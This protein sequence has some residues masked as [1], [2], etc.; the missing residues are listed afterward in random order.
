MDPFLTIGLKL[1]TEPDEYL[2]RTKLSATVAELDGERVTEIQTEQ[3][4]EKIEALQVVDDIEEAKTGVVRLVMASKSVTG[5]KGQAGQ[6]RRLLEYC[7]KGAGDKSEALLAAMPN[8]LAQSIVAEIAKV[9]D[10]L[11]PSTTRTEVT[12]VE[13]WSPTRYRREPSSGDRLGGEF[14]RG[15]A[16]T[17]W[18]KGMFEQAWFDTSP[19]RDVANI[20]DDGDEI[21]AWARLHLNDVPILWRGGAHTYNP[22]L[23]AVGGDS[24]YWLVEVKADR[25]METKVV[26]EKRDA[27]KQWANFVNGSDLVK[28]EWGYLLA[29]ETTIR[30]ANG[31]WK[32]L[33]ALAG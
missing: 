26:Q 15:L 4:R 24:R 14:T 31:S 17:G 19:E 28:G 30:N 16:Y 20:L 21:V 10:A 13:Q 7:L 33:K 2:R 5:R 23:L 12:A 9:R 8:A 18:H 27:A 25:D 1:A 6:V 32:R 11:P 29:S 22:D 3:A